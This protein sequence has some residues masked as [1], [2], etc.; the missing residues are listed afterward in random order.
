LNI[1]DQ[2]VSHEGQWIA[3]QQIK[4]NGSIATVYNIRV[5]VDHTYFVG[6]VDW[7]FSVW[8]HNADYVIENVFGRY[9]FKDVKTGNFGTLSFATREEAETVLNL[10]VRAKLSGQ[11][12][13]EGEALASELTGAPKNTELFLVNGRGRIPDQVLAM[14]IATK[15]PSIVAEVKNVK[16]QAFTRQLRDDI[17]LVGPSGQVNV[18]LPPGAEVT[19]PLGRAFANPRLPLNRLDL[20]PPQ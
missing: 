20:V 15:R 13:R 17:E 9:F 2:L 10:S 7:G 5:A 1:G 11:L 8:V 16:R 18:Y 19:K 6:D 3:V 4:D 14:D 12:G